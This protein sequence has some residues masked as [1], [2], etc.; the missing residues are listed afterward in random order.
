SQSGVPLT[1]DI[2]VIDVTTCQPLPDVMIE[3]WS[4][5]AVGEY[6]ET[7]LRGGTKTSSNGIAE[8][9]T[10][11][12]GH[13]SDSANHINLVVHATGSMAGQVVH[14]GQVFFTDKWTDVINENEVFYG[15]DK[16]ANKRVV[17]AE[18][19]VFN[20][21]NAGG[22]NP[23]VDIESIE[24]D[25]PTGVVGYISGWL[26]VLGMERVLTQPEQR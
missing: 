8:F 3:V 10:I 1:L 2:G 19:A 6:G 24:D 15:Y 9:E 18:D 16:N 23:I 21:A 12:P 22:F 26:A 7:F 11:F 25:W 13:T 14:I 17:N 20:A 4:A 5:N